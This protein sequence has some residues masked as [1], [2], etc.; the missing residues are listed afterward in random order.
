MQRG[1]EHSYLPSQKST[2][3]ILTFRTKAENRNLPFSSDFEHHMGST[4][5]SHLFEAMME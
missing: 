5:P 3:L 4:S 2:I 1:A